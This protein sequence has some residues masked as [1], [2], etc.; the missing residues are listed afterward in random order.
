MTG[1]GLASLVALA[2]NDRRAPLVIHYHNEWSVSKK[3]RAS[4]LQCGTLAETLLI[5]GGHLLQPADVPK[6]S[7]ELIF[8]CSSDGLISI[9]VRV[10]AAMAVSTFIFPFSPRFQRI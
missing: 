7:V 6:A 3:H 10:K 2:E 9:G 5:V 8:G 1:L 4:S